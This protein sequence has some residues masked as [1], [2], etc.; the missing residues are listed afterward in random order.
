[1]ITLLLR[2][3]VESSAFAFL[4]FLLTLAFK[5]SAVVRHRLFVM[6][7]L[8]FAV[9]L[10][11][12]AALGIAVGGHLAFAPV[13]LPVLY[14]RGLDPVVNGPHTVLAS[15]ASTPWLQAVAA[16]VWV[17]GVVLTGALWLRRLGQHFGEPAQAPST[18]TAEWQRC[19][20][21]LALRPLP[22]LHTASEAQGPCVRGVLRP[23]VILPRG[24]EEQLEPE[25][26]SAVLLHELVHVTGRDNLR[27]A[28]THAVACV[29]W[30]F[31]CCCGWSVG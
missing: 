9:P 6:A 14:A 27:A 5:N 22:A 25:A 20:T 8:K 30:F 16:T 24:L 18:V 26:F 4:L 17:A 1:M 31:L 11:L 12:F 28:I 10:Q 3:L 15:Q 29:F 23:E 19:A 2:H 13:R 7:A 21:L